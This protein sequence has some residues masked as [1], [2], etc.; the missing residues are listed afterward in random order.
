MK[1]GATTIWERWNSLGEDGKVSS[2]G[3]NSFNHY[4]YGAILE[5]MFRHVAALT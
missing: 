4:A 2:T 5:W 3:M 1:L